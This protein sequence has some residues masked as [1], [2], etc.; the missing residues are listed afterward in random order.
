MHAC[1]MVLFKKQHA[2]SVSEYAPIAAAQLQ[3]STDDATREQTKRK[4]DI[5]YMIAKENLPFT[6]MKAVCGLEERHGAE[7]GQGYKNDRHLHNL[8][9]GTQSHY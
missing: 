3:L 9:I 5:A 1:A 2:S 8:K 6:K 4:F 7:L